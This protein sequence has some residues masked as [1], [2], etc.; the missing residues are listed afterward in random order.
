MTKL[1]INYAQITNYAARS[2]Y[3]MRTPVEYCTT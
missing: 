2:I 1:N 3:A